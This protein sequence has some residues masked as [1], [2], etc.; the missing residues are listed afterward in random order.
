MGKMPSGLLQGALFW[1]GDFQTCLNIAHQIEN[2]TEI[3]KGKYCSVNQMIKN[4]TIVSQPNVKGLY[5]NQRIG[6]IIVIFQ[7][8]KYWLVCI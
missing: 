3:W 1:T 5:F 4:K 8:N 2:T 6:T 7:V